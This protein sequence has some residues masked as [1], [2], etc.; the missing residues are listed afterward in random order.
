MKN[1]TFSKRHRILKKREFFKIFNEKDRRIGDF[2]CVDV[3]YT[4]KNFSCPRLGI[5]VSVRFG[6]AHDR[7]RFKRQIREM[8]RKEKERLPCNLE[9]NVI[10]RKKGRH[11]KYSELHQELFSLIQS[12]SQ[13]I[14]PS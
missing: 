14:L 5:T 2:L 10:P 7:N 12:S 13:S 1:E 9:I 11:R 6:K 3:L 4:R 8:F